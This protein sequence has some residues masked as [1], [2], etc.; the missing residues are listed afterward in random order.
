MAGLT[1]QAVLL[2]ALMLVACAPVQPGALV[3]NNGWII[4]RELLP[5]RQDPGK[6]VEVFWAKPTGSGPWPAVLFIHGHQEQIRNG[7]E[8]Y[9]VTGRLGVMARRGFVAASLS[10]PGYGNSD[11][12]PDFCG[13]FT[14]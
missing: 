1:R 10:Q 7:G 2:I 14:Q 11:G 12:S 4:Q 5:H 6:R 3:D 13:P 9:A 8:A